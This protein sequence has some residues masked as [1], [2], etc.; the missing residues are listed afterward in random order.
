[1]IES[2]KYTISINWKYISKKRIKEKGK[3]K[4]SWGKRKGE[5]EEREREWGVWKRK[6]SITLISYK[7]KRLN[8]S[9]FFFVGVSALS[10]TQTL[11]SRWASKPTS[12]FYLK[13]FPF[14]LSLIFPQKL[15]SLSFSLFIYKAYA[16]NSVAFLKHL[17]D[18]LSTLNTWIQWDF[19]QIKPKTENPGE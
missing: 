19:P 12:N 7:W 17:R 13:V 5:E 16:I 15:C 11:S 6:Q 2:E 9:F 14:S 18:L 10:R 4:M 3:F 1:M 8:F